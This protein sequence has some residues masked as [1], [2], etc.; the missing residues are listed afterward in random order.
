M[1]FSQI[2]MQVNFSLDSFLAQVDEV[3][4]SIMLEISNAMAFP[5]SSIHF[6]LSGKKLR[7]RFVYHSANI[8]SYDAKVQL[9]VLLELIHSASLVH[10][11]IVDESTLR[12]GFS[13]LQQQF[14]TKKA[15][16]TGYKMFSLIFSLCDSLSP[17]WRNCFYLTLQQMCLGEIWELEDINNSTRSI[18]QYK[19]SVIYKTAS[20]FA[21]SCGLEEAD[22]WNSESA[23]FGLHY[24]FAF[25][26]YDD[27]LDIYS[28][29]QKTGKTSKKDASLGI[30]TL[31]EMLYS[32][33][34]SRD[35]AIKKSTAIGLSYLNKAENYSDNPAWISE[36]KKLAKRYLDL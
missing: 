34:N 29:Q 24:G 2:L 9:G 17:H 30:L 28:N 26:L 25:Q 4:R 10:D 11:D 27:L 18:S 35:K 31:P 22:L 14:L 8:T 15:I 19:K 33:Y 3:T 23:N 32:T 5:P 36:A 1:A 21:L 12:R 7:S 20:L 13:T 6:L 16:N